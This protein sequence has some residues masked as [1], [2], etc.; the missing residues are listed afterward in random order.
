MIIRHAQQEEISKIITLYDQAKSY[1][2]KKNIFQWQDGY[3]NEKTL[4]DD[5]IKEGSYVLV[6]NDEI[7]GSMYFAIEDEES[8]HEITNGRWLTDNPYSVIHRIVIDENFKGHSL[9]SK[10]LDYCIEQSLNKN[11]HS[12]RIDTHKDNLSMQKFLIKNRFTLCGDITL[13]NGDPRIGFEKIIGRVK[14]L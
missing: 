12:I 7:I 6:H 1:F 13:K 11:I 8:Y 3:P 10:M 4:L 14:S 2:R 9:A 5:I